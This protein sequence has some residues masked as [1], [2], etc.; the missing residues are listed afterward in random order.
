[1]E[2][3][4]AFIS[5]RLFKLVSKFSILTTDANTMMQPIQLT[6]MPVILNEKDTE[7]WLT[8]SRQ[9]TLQLQLPR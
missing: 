5:Q 2:T 6:A 4:R 8:A 7:S 9:I 3:D 1:M